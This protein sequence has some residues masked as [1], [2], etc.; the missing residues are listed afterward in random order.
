MSVK[1]RMLKED[2]IKEICWDTGATRYSAT[3]VVDSLLSNIRREIANGNSVMLKD[4]GT[5]EAKKR[6][7]RTG[8]NPHTNT[9]VPIPA[10]TV[11]NFKPAQKFKDAVK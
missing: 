6:A 11:P 10:K 4:F 7:P 8:R 3:R 2:I 5:F 1:V 9:P